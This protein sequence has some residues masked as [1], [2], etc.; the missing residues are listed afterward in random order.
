MVLPVNNYAASQTYVSQ[1]EVY[2]ILYQVLKALN[3]EE[4]RIPSREE[5]Y[6]ADDL[7]AVHRDFESQ[8][9]IIRRVPSERSIAGITRESSSNP[10]SDL[11]P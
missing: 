5:W 11:R 2:K 3:V 8:D 1:R 7:V 10:Q 6:R 9:L 4:V